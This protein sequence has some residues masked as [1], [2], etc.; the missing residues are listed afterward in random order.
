MSK[1]KHLNENLVPIKKQ[2]LFKE[3]YIYQLTQITN[4]AKINLNVTFRSTKLPYKNGEYFYFYAKDALNDTIKGVAFND[5]IKNF[6]K[7]VQNESIEI[8][9]FVTQKIPEN[10]SKTND[11]LQI[12]IKPF[13]SIKSISN[14]EINT[15]NDEDEIEDFTKIPHYKQISIIAKIIDINEEEEIQ[16][17]NKTIKKKTF[18]LKDKFAG[19]IIFTAWN[20]SIQTFNNVNLEKTI[21]LKNIKS[22]SFKNKICLNSTDSTS[23]EYLEETTIELLED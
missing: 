14:F 22:S 20:K 9:N 18:L 6:D 11:E 19:E 2:K 4:D 5:A 8:S 16:K 13:T 10:Y 17:K 7:I 1:R 23:F 12:I 15:N 3:K 21:K